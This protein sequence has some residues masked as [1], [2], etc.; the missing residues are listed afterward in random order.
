MEIIPDRFI[1]YMTSTSLA[2]GGM[3]AAPTASHSVCFRS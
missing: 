1:S 3:F 2:C